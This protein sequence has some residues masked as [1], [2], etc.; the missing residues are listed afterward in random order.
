[1]IPLFAIGATIR[2]LAELKSIGF[3][4]ALCFQD[5]VSS[6]QWVAACQRVGIGA[7]A[8]SPGCRWWDVN[9]PEPKIWSANGVQDLKADLEI[10]RLTEPKAIPIVYV[11]GHYRPILVAEIVTHNVVVALG[12]YARWY[13]PSKFPN[14]WSFAFWRPYRGFPI[15][16]NCEHGN[17]DWF[18][19]D[20]HASIAGGACGIQIWRPSPLLTKPDI[21]AE[22]LNFVELLRNNEA[23]LA[24][25]PDLQAVGSEIHEPFDVLGDKGAVVTTVK[26]VPK[27]ILATWTRNVF[28]DTVSGFEK[29][30]VTL[31]GE[32]FS[33]TRWMSRKAV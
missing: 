6:E 7:V 12:N 4:D 30:S 26:N 13:G 33:S 14:P 28:H 19:F 16:L 5:D 11:P 18:A 22:W 9:P 27:S 20:L 24:E 29:F 15:A 32:S 23:V 31:D 10:A 1:M 25:R 2:E 3:T 8:R 21:Q 17:A